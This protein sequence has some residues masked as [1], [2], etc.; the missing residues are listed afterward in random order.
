MT[1]LLNSIE[2]EIVKPLIF[3]LLA[4]AAIYF[5]WGV[6]MF[7]QSYDNESKRADYKRHMVYGIIGLGIMLSVQGIIDLIKDTVS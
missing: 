7:V 5:V 1:E 6:F 3:F 4:L 2:T